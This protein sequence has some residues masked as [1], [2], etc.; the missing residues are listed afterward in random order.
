MAER[1]TARAG[2]ARERSHRLLSYSPKSD[3][4]VME[5]HIDVI[6]LAVGELDRS[7]AFYRDGLARPRGGTLTPARRLREP[8]LE[9]AMH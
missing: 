5:R 9:S 4:Q 6:T 8:K 1:R 2:L 7:L 3:D